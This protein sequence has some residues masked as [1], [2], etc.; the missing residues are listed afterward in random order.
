[1]ARRLKQNLSRSKKN[2]KNRS[3][4]ANAEITVQIDLPSTKL[5][6]AVYAS[7]LPETVRARPYRSNIR[8]AVSGRVLKLVI[9][10]SDIVA[11]RAASN[12]FL[13]LVAVAMKTLNIVAPFY[14][15]EMS[16]EDHLS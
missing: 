3:A 12:S 11:L 1:M 9:T 14:T 13:R 4:Q 10:A 2:R 7:V 6:R 15:S 5:A 8:L 16:T